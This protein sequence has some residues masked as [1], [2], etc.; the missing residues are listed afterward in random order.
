MVRA[1]GNDPVGYNVHLLEGPGRLLIHAHSYPHR[2]KTTIITGGGPVLLN[3]PPEPTL[4]TM[5]ETE[6][7]IGGLL[8]IP[9][10]TGYIGWIG[11]A[12]A[13]AD[14]YNIRFSRNATMGDYAAPDRI[15]VPPL[16]VTCESAS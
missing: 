3:S 14:P 11:L 4:D 15:V 8:L 7:V 9:T 2:T 13:G 1:P 12:G 16:P 5:E 10:K 6:T